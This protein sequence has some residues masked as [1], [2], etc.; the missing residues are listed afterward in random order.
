MVANSNIKK[1]HNNVFIK[2]NSTLLNSSTI[3]NKNL[4]LIKKLNIRNYFT[5]LITPLKERKN[6]INSSISTMDIQ[7]IEFKGKQIPFS[8]S[9]A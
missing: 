5:S 8:I 7:T 1:H 3:I 6:I 9:T 4:Q 2:K